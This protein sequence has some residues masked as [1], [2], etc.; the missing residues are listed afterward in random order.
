VTATVA[1]ERWVIE[2]LVYTPI[3]SDGRALGPEAVE[4]LAETP[5]PAPLRRL[6]LQMADESAPRGGGPPLC[7]ARV[8]LAGARLPAVTFADLEI[9]RLERLWIAPPGSDPATTGRV[10]GGIARLH[11]T[12]LADVVWRGIEAGLLR[13]I[14]IRAF[15]APDATALVAVRLGPREESCLAGARVVHSWTESPPVALG[16]HLVVAG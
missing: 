12:A 5:Q 1:V 7:L 14:S 8:Q 9:G 4:R 16:G 10:L 2:D 3:V 6:H 13:G 15:V 11:E